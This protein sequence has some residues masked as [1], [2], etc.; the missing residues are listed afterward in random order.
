MRSHAYAQ[1]VFG[2]AEFRRDLPRFETV[3]RGLRGLCG[4]VEELVRVIS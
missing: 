1:L 3:L 4:V 2:H